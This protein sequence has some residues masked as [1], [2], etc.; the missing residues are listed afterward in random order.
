MA[1]EEIEIETAVKMFA[2]IGKWSRYA[3]PEPGAIGCRATPALLAQCGLGPDGRRL[4]PA[5]LQAA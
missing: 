5:K 3:G 1:G 4:P 2:K